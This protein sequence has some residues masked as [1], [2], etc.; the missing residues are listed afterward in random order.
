MKGITFLKDQTNNK[1]LLQIDIAAFA[2]SPGR[3]EDLIDIIIAEAR[4]NEKKVSWESAKKQ[5]KK[6]GK[7]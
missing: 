6:A 4:K 1:D 3:L 2:K 5:L 7:L